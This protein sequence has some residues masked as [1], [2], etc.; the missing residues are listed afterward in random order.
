MELTHLRYFIAVAEELHF[1]RAAAKLHIAQPPLSQQ[2]KRLED[3][4][5]VK[6]FNRTSRRVELSTAGKILLPEA[7]GIVER[8]NEACAIMTSLLNGQ[9][10]YLSVAFNEPSINTFLPEVIKNFTSKYPEVKLSL[11]ELG[12]IEQFKAFDEKRIHLGFMRPFGDDIRAY[13][14]RLVQREQYVLALPANHR[15]CAFPLLTL[16]MIRDEPLILVVQKHHRLRQRFDKCFQLSGFKPNVI[17]EL[18]SKH[19][20]LALV[21]AG[22]GLAFVPESSIIYS[23]FGV[24]FRKLDSNLPAF[25]IFALWRP[26]DDSKLIEN[27]LDLIPATI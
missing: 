12:I 7:R 2:I 8:A 11:N 25:E 5:N 15:L 16:D 24:E 18:D 3:E 1:G 9:S 6:L 20:M 22:V 21:K 27:F 14:K 19:A 17:Q 10:G 13:S 4:L 23:P 26:E